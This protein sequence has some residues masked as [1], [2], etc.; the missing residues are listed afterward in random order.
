M[1]SGLIQGNIKGVIPRKLHHT[2]TITAKTRSKV[3][4]ASDFSCLNRSPHAALDHYHDIVTCKRTKR[5]EMQSGT[6]EPRLQKLVSV[7]RSATT[8]HFNIGRRKFDK[9]IIVL[10]IGTIL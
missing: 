8:D 4:F 3:S 6:T 2:L 10:P 7:T 1:K 9:A 5:G